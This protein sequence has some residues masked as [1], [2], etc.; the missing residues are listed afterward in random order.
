MNYLDKDMITEAILNT[1]RISDKIENYSLFNETKIPLTP[2]PP[3]DEW[4]PINSEIINKYKNI[5]ELYNDTYEHHTYLI[6]KI[7]EG[8]DY[9]KIPFVE[10]KKTLERIDLECSELVG[11]TQNLK[12]PMGAYLT[13]MQK[14]MDIIWQVS[15]VGC[16]R[17]SAVGWIINYLLDITQINPLKQEG[18]ELQHW[19]FLCQERPDFPKQYWGLV[20]NPTKG[21][22]A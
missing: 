8:I 10:M 4:Y 22:V 9:R 18:M 17:G 5:K 20:V 1:K 6:H 11:I 13:T 7:F 15:V 21:C 12:E 16:G 14:N 3:K 2:L 19:R